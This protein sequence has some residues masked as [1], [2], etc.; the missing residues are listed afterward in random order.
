MTGCCP[1][2]CTV[3]SAPR[4]TFDL[5]HRGGS[6]GARSARR[7]TRRVRR[8][9]RRT[10][11]A[12][13]QA[14][15]CAC[16]HMLVALRCRSPR[17]GRGRGVGTGG[18]AGCRGGQVPRGAAGAAHQR[19]ARGR[20]GGGRLAGRGRATAARGHVAHRQRSRACFGAQRP[21]WFEHAC[22]RV[23]CCARRG[24]GWCVHD[25]ARTSTRPGCA[26]AWLVAASRV[27]GCG[28]G[29]SSGRAGRHTAW[30]RRRGVGR[31]GAVQC[32]L[33]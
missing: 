6:G 24:V 12:H 28:L 19:S 29:G 21:G 13:S 7:H 31:H 23:A 32:G 15:E 27:R 2:R 3:S 22:A 30:G 4:G 26:W 11:H 17:W 9:G 33:V 16:T 20:A 18:R 14:C 25:L 10:R 5:I 8:C 1:G